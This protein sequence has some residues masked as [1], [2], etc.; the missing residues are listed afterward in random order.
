MKAPKPQGL[1]VLPQALLAAL[2][3]LGFAATLTACLP[4]EEDT[5][6]SE[7]GPTV[8]DDTVGQDDDSAT[9]S[10][11]R[12]SYAITAHVPLQTGV[13]GTLSTRVTEYV[14]EDADSEPIEGNAVLR[15]QIDTARY[16]ISNDTLYIWPAGDCWAERYTG[17]TTTL[18]GTWAI[19]S[20]SPTT[21][22]PV[23]S[24][25]ALCEEIY[26]ECD[27]FGDCG[28]GTDSELAQLLN[29]V[30]VSRTLTQDSLIS[31]FTGTF[32]YAGLYAGLFVKV[33]GG[34]VITV[35]ESGCAAA[36][37]RDSETNGTAAFRSL[38]DG[39]KQII[40]FR[41]AGTTCLLTES[42]NGYTAETDCADVGVA[43][44]DAFVSCI[45][46]TG[47]FDGARA[48]LSLDKKSLTAEALRMEAALETLRGGLTPFRS[49]R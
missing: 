9:A 44:T 39:P 47:F 33:F 10:V 49:R 18:Q 45:L 7:G 48:A 38:S 16:V 41:H 3:V 42:L 30:T 4:L 22:I 46:E 6:K 13:P 40:A 27:Q 1:A 28:D 34:D 35:E 5:K 20:V 14:C 2:L 17:S 12:Q 32:C 15:T 19:D 24:R 23:G 11:W 26:Q 36:T 29:G 21:K 25:S 43:G 8:D 31:T 37:L